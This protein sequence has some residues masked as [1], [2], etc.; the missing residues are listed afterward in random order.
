MGEKNDRPHGIQVQHPARH[1]F[2]EN[3]V[4]FFDDSR[5]WRQETGFEM[6]REGK[7]VGECK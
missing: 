5:Q 3:D 7:W 1:E 6:N 2:H 4:I